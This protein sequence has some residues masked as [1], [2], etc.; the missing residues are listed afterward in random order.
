[1][2]LWVKYTLFCRPN[3]LHRQGTIHFMKKWQDLFYSQLQASPHAPRNGRALCSPDTV[4]VAVTI[5][6]VCIE[7]THTI[8][9]RK[10]DSAKKTFHWKHP[11]I[12]F[13]CRFLPWAQ[14]LFLLFSFN[15]KG[16]RESTSYRRLVVAAFPLGAS[17]RAFELC[18]SKGP[19]RTRN[20]VRA[21]FPQHTWFLTRH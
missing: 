21:A 1:M 5:V 17:S 10:E 2:C 18:G 12:S 6:C 13:N 8:K 7:D 11:D 20:R 9:P 3:K 19:T 14:L 16:H 15:F 4:A